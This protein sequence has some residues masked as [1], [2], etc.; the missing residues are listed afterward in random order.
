MDQIGSL[1]GPE[2]AEQTRAM[3]RQAGEHLEEGGVLTT[4]LGLGALLFGATGAFAQLQTALN[5]AWGVRPD[6][7][8][9]GLR[10]FFIKRVLSL[11][12]VL[13]IAFLLL[14]SLVVSTMLSAFGEVLAEAVP[15]LGQPL[16]FALNIVLSLAVITVLFAALF[17]VLPDAEVGWRDVWVGAAATAVLFVAGKFVI[18]LYLGQSNPG[19]V[20]GAAGSLVVILIWI[21]YSAMILFLDI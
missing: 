19:S 11:S 2:A 8:Q 15:F 14:V 1:V 4:M 12:M 21:Y 18:G 16:L 6:P 17:K 5:T 20:F 13:G 9:G 7:A 10:N 3:V